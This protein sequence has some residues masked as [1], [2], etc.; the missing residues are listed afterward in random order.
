MITPFPYL[1][2]F[3]LEQ[4]KSLKQMTSDLENIGHDT[5]KEK[6]KIHEVEF[7]NHIEPEGNNILADL[8]LSAYHRDDSLIEHS[9]KIF[10]EARGENERI[11]EDMFFKKFPGA[12][13]TKI[14]VFPG[15]R[16]GGLYLNSIEL[17]EVHVQY[18]YM[19][20]FGPIDFLVFS[21]EAK[22]KFQ[23]KIYNA[24]DLKRYNTIKA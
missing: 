23:D 11:F 19:D 2:H 12:K 15:V 9:N 24:P 17:K 10:R 16:T 20:E 21:I 3:L 14:S 5:S 1:I 13:L 22:I 7:E 8:N 18:T 4:V 6:K